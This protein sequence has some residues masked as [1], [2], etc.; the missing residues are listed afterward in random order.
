MARAERRFNKRV[1]GKFKISY[2]HDGDYLFSYTKDISADGMFIYVKNPPPVGESIDLTFSIGELNNVSV[3]A[4]VS[5]INAF[6]SSKDTGMG[7]R[8]IN[9]PPALKEAILDIIHRIAVTVD[10]D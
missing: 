2:I 1:P 9:T 7:V 3:A 4:E 5:W 6:V 8:F 10:P